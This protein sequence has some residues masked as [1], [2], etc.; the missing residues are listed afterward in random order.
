MEVRMKPRVLLA[1]LL[2]C[3]SCAASVAVA[4]KAPAQKTVSAVVVN[5]GLQ[6][7]QPVPTV[8]ISLSYLDGSVR[9]TESRDVTNHNGQA[10]LDVSE[11]VA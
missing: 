1:V 3:L 10:W 2:F 6:P 5:A 7:A 8:R 4:Q 11:D 9:V